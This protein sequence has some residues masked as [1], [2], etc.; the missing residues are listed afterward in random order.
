MMKVKI[1]NAT[2]WKKQRYKAGSVI[3]VP[4]EIAE[5]NEW[6]KPTDEPLSEPPAPK[7][8]AKAKDDK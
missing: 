2:V 4:E 5:Q 8:A 1:E 6:M 7:E 3:E